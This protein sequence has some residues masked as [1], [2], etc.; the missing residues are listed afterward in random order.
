MSQPEAP[1]PEFI[2]SHGIW[3]GEGKISFTSSP[4]FIKFY[5]RWQIAPEDNGLIKAVQ[6]VEMQGIGEQITNTFQFNDITSIDF[7]VSL[8]NSLVG[9][10]SG[11]G[12][13]T[14]SCTVAWEFRSQGS[15]EGFEVYERQENGDYFLHAEYGSPDQFRT[16]VEG[17]VWRKESPEQC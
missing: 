5:T 15:F 13:R 2:F 16:I 9:K 14:E 4:E 12:M 7:S 8:E 17:L 11:K 3:L 1:L 6:V 10:I